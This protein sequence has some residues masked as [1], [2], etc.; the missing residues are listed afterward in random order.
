MSSP[1]PA[2][3]A[4]TK[5]LC[6]LGPATN[7]PAFVRGLIAAGASI[8]RVNF[9]HGTP[10]EHARAV[11]LVREAEAEGDRVLAVLADL[12]GPKVRL[13]SMHP[14]P[15]RF[16][17][18]QPFELRPGGSGDDLGAST[19]YAGLAGDL[20]EGDRVLLADGAVELVVTAIAEGTVTTECLRGGFVRSGQGVNVPAERLGLPAVTDRDR[21]GLARALDLGVDLIA[22]SFVRVADDLYEL[23][24]LMGDR[25]VPIVAKIE[26]KPAVENIDAILEATD[27]LMVARGDL[28][29]ELPMEQIPLLQKDLLRRALSASRPVVVAT[30][31]LESMIRAPRPTRAEATD[32]ANAVLDGADA[33]MLSG[34][35]A[36]GEYPFEAAAAATKI[37]AAVEARAGDYRAARPGCRHTGEAAAVAHAVADVATSEAEV[38]AITCYTE[39]GRTARLLSAER[40][41]SPIYAFIPDHQVR[42]VNTLNWGVVPIAAEHPDDT[43]AMIALMDEGLRRRSLV[44][45]GELVV[46]AAASPAGR[47]TTNMLK[48]HQVGSPVR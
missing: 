41:L 18:G 10:A 4:R 26:T 43:D 27:A 35:T 17:P 42:R 31:M 28:G 11:A 44:A 32:V 22:Q 1:S 14:D 8:F 37:A 15:F 20:R 29:V 39:T 25:V 19:T 47:T 13:G 33:I 45:P 24:S 23:R 34:E 9:S 6:T 2:L 12:P 36:I 7:T 40:P 5:L 38:V 48:F 16:T 30:Q 21:E 3:A 46:M